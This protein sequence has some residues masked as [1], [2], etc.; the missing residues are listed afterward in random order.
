MGEE[1][2]QLIQEGDREGLGEKWRE[3]ERKGRE[4]ERERAGFSNSIVFVW[5]I[6][7]GT[8]KE[9][10]NMESKVCSVIKSEPLGVRILHT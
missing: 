2:V 8:R 3:R 4:G 1:A 10:M 9:S 5:S 6:I 7:P